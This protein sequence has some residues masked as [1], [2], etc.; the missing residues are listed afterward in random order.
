MRALVLPYVEDHLFYVEHWFHSLFWGK[1]R[2]VGKILE[3]A[4]FFENATDIWFL[5]RDEI[6]QALWDHVHQL[7]HRRTIDEALPTGRRRSPGE[8][9]SIRSSRS[10]R[11]R[12]ALGT[13]PD[14]V[15]EPFTIVLW[16]VTTNVLAEMAQGA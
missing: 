12:P 15:T 3:D 5:K 6:K 8:R 4:G 7:G 10:G 1:V 2:Q 11:R 9:A 14:V 16:G 13:P